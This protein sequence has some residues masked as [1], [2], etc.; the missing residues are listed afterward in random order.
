MYNLDSAAKLFEDLLLGSKVGGMRRD[1]K[2][3]GFDGGDEQL[4][5]GRG[6]KVV[7]ENKN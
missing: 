5:I 7:G 2:D 1:S 6:A 3:T 4:V